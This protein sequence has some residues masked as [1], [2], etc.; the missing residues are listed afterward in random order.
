[1]GEQRAV[2][3]AGAAV[4]RQAGQVDGLLKH[5]FAQGEEF[6]PVAP[7]GKRDGLRCLRTFK[8]DLVQRG[9]GIG[10]VYANRRLE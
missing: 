6:F 9:V 4:L 3:Q 2:F 5:V 10:R 7:P 8:L 1:V